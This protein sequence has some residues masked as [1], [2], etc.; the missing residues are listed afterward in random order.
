[1]KTN[2]QIRELYSR[3]TGKA[4]YVIYWSRDCDMYESTVALMFYSLRE[5]LEYQDDAARD[6][7]GPYSFSEITRQQYQEFTPSH[8]DRAFEAYENGRGRSIYV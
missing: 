5:Y 1:M 7:E 4:I 3:I 6:A 8:R 2:R